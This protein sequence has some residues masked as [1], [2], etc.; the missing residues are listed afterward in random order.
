MLAATI[1]EV[2]ASVQGEGSWVG[3]RHLFVRFTGC[4]LS[5]RYCDTRAAAMALSDGRERSCR[6]QI[7]PESFDRESIPNPI[8]QRRFCRSASGW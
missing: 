5:C 2:F 1:N 8:D 3:Q 4:D 6:A 7:S